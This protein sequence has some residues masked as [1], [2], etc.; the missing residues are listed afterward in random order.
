M[1]N[2]QKHLL[3]APHLHV[4]LTLY[5]T[6]KIFLK[7]PSTC[8]FERFTTNENESH[9]TFVD[10]DAIEFFDGVIIWFNILGSATTG[11]IPQHADMC[12]AALDNFGSEVQLQKL[13]S[14]EN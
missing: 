1:E 3:A 6:Q 11:L 13:I 14:C 7:S 8:Y 5:C 9:I 4:F 2:W 12:V 10:Y